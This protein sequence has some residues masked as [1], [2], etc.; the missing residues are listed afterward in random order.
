LL[1]APLLSFSILE[2]YP[3]A[4]NVPLLQAKGKKC[5]LPVPIFLL[6]L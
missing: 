5:Y 3:S 6:Y 1:G 4:A 2:D